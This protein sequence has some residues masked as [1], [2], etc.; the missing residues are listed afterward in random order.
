M[1]IA[2]SFVPAWLSYRFIEAPFRHSVR[3]ALPRAALTCG[4]VG[5]V[6]AVLAGALGAV[7]PK[8]HFKQASASAA[9]GAAAYDAKDWSKVDAVKA[10][11]P[12]PGA[13]DLPAIYKH[14]CLVPQAEFGLVSCT[15]THPSAKT[16]VALVGDSKAAQWFTPLREI[17]EDRGWKLVTIVK[18]NCAFTD[19]PRF[20]PDGH[21]NPSCDEWR[22]KAAER[23]QHLAPDIVITSSRRSTALPPGARKESQQTPK[24]MI[25]GLT[26]SWSALLDAGAKVVPIIDNPVPPDDLADCILEN[27]TELSHCAFRPAGKHSSGAFAQL[28]AAK[29]LDLPVVDLRD[30]ICPRH[31]C[32]VVIGNVLVYRDGSHLTDTFAKTAKKLLESR[33]MRALGQQS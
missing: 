5:I 32:P 6:V 28:K 3:L 33:L 14:H 30:V 12:V 29:R 8:P 18:M 25:D 2:A 13:K 20:N 10:I 15:W 7:S 19:A 24:A 1:V 22:G 16:T 9:P 31:R 21:R 23:L 26:R 4:A 27:A 11:R 17:A